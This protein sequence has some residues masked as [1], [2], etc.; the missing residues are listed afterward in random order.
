RQIR[1]RAMEQWATWNP[2]A[3]FFHFSTKDLPFAEGEANA[4]RFLSGRLA[5][6]PIPP[7][8]KSYS[9]RSSVKLPAPPAPGEFARVLLSR[10]TWRRFG[11]QPLALAALS[12]LMHL[13]FGAQK[14]LD[15]GL[16]G[17]AMQRTS[18]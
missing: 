10:R 6:K 9:R 3:G 15:L 8:A 13:T 18:P 1:E 7:A 11:K 5:A 16:G 2:A 12:S 4:Q 14:F 17:T